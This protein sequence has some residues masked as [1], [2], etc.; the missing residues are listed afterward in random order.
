MRFINNLSYLAVAVALSS[1]FIG[2]SSNKEDSQNQAITDTPTANAEAAIVADSGNNPSTGDAVASADAT[3]DADKSN[4]TTAVVAKLPEAVAAKSD[5]TAKSVEPDV[6]ENAV[7]NKMVASTQTPLVQGSVSAAEEKKPVVPLTPRPVP[8]KV[9]DSDAT[10]EATSA[11]EK[12]DLIE[13]DASNMDDP[14][15]TEEDIVALNDEPAKEGHA[16][17]TSIVP[18]SYCKLYRMMKTGQVETICH[19]IM[20]M[21]DGA[22]C[23]GHSRNTCGTGSEYVFCSSERYANN[24]D[25]QF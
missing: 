24:T 10:K 22:Y 9:T 16:V 15:L 20:K 14:T 13:K 4:L 21:A 6:A 17:C 3:T 2:C 8:V 5:Q 18:D 19:G 23:F 11:E 7:N 25:T 1:S 12:T